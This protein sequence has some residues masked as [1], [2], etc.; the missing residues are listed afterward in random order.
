MAETLARTLVL[1]PTELEARR[2]RTLGALEPGPLR[3]ELCGFGPLAAAARTAQCL[4]RIHP[5]RVLLLGIA[6]SL[7]PEL[8]PLE[9]ALCFARV[10]LDGVGAGRGPDFRHPS[11]LGFPQWPGSPDTGSDPIGETLPLAGPKTA[12]GSLLTVCAASASGEEVHERRA[13]F[14]EALAEDM[15]G[16]GVALACRLAGV[17]LAIVRGFSNAAG[18]RD[19]RLW[20][21][22]GAMRAAEEL[23]CELL[24]N[25][26]WGGRP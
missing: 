12:R 13:R 18:E 20:R 7:D 15:E 2:L 24:E 9:S 10:E 3:L 23:A 11:A 19:P 16:F 4:E 25:E 17:P 8:A 6:G 1:V 5:G 14:P 26:R 22:A 21:S